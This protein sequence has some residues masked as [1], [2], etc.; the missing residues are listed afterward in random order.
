MS[1]QRSQSI[2]YPSYSR[3]D[4]ASIMREKRIAAHN[5]VKYLAN[6]I[7]SLSNRRNPSTRKEAKELKIELIKAKTERDIREKMCAQT[8]KHGDNATP[9]WHYARQYSEC[10]HRSDKS[11]K[12]AEDKFCVANNMPEYVRDNYHHELNQSPLQDRNL[13]TAYNP[14]LLVRTK[15]SLQIKLIERT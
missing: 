14:P 9:F 1:I 8:F 15:R 10:Y 2:S 5:D 12:S 13:I 3:N 6:E 11:K 7:S 4:S